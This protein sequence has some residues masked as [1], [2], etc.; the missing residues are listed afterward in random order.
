MLE[1]KMEDERH[2]MSTDIRKELKVEQEK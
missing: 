1:A 2:S